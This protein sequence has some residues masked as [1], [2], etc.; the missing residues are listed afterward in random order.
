MKRILIRIEYDGSGFNGY[1]KQP[2]ARTVQGELERALSVMHK[3]E[4]W[5]CTSSGRTDTGVHGVRQPVHFDSSLSI[6]EKRWPMALNSLL[7]DD[8]QVLEAEEVDASFHARYDTVGKVY[9]YRVDTVKRQTVF[10]RA[11]AAHFPGNM[12]IE[13]MREAAKHLEGTHD[14]T[15]LSSPKTDVKDKVRTL[16]AVSLEE[17]ED[18]FDVVFAG[19]GFLYQMVRI[20]MGTLI[21]VGSGDWSPD[22]IP[23]LIEKQDRHAAGPTAPGHGLYLEDVFYT[24]GALDACVKSLEEKK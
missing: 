20:L 16:F 22:V 10:R 6:P 18:G 2:N 5:P 19:S 3:A 17:R 8:I 12:N 23:A 11:F 4:S 7:P 13:A 14:F 9:R 21:K 15:S 24:E 1:Q